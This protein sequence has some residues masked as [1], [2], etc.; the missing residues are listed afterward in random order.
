MKE[1]EEN[2]FEDLQSEIVNLV[3]N[4]SKENKIDMMEYVTVLVQ[5]GTTLFKSCNRVLEI[6]GQAVNSNKE[7]ITFMLG[8]IASLIEEIEG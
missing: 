5:G 7:F 2:R 8:E 6:Q 1:N 4:H 3:V